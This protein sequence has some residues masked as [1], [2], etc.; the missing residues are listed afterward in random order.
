MM[1][2][3]LLSNKNFLIF[4]AQHYDNPGCTSTE[5]FQEDIRRVKYVKKLVTRFIEHNEL[6][7]RLILNHL[8]VLSNVF[9]P[10]VL[11]RILW[12][13][14]EYQ[15]EYVKPFLVML[16]VLVDHVRNVKS[17]R[18]IDTSLVPMNQKIVEVLR[19]I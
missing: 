14:M 3:D 8:I 17:E 11:C 2:P 6:K 19:K 5:E 18:I 7:E 15:M 10:E 9:T 16:G 4:A 1:V 13:K 12:L